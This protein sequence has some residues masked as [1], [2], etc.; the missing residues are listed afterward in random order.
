MYTVTSCHTNKTCQE[1]V[2]EVQDKYYE[3]I[4]TGRKSLEVRKN[5]PDSWGRVQ[6]GDMLIVKKQGSPDF[7]KRKVVEV[8]TYSFLKEALEQ[9]GIRNVLP[10]VE[11]MREAIEIYM[12]F[13]GDDPEVID[14]R[15]TEFYVYG[16]IVMELSE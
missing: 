2:L 5:K 6:K 15:N 12:G 14:R 8:R 1:Y 3:L 11:S 9:E 4:R 10:G 16:C 13:D 7:Y